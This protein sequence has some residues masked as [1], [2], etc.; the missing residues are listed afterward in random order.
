MN[1]AIEA[2]KFRSSLLTT[3]LY[4]LMAP[5]YCV[6]KGLHCTRNTDKT[7]ERQNADIRENWKLLPSNYWNK[8]RPQKWH[9]H[10]EKKNRSETLDKAFYKEQ[11]LDSILAKS[12]LY[13]EICFYFLAFLLANFLIRRTHDLVPLI[14]D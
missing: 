6:I 5:K 8:D 2:S 7:G 1:F 13:E 10:N 12:Y 3:P 9:K 14:T 4:I 11:T